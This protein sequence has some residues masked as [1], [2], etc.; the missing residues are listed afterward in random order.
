MAI[1]WVITPLRYLGTIGYY[2]CQNWL[3]LKWHQET[4][5]HSPLKSWVTLPEFFLSSFI[6]EYFV[7]YTNQ[8]VYGKIVLLQTSPIIRLLHGLCSCTC[9]FLCYAS[10]KEDLLGHVLARASRGKTPDVVVY[11]YHC[12]WF[13]S[14]RARG[15][16]SSN[17][18]PVWGP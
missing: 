16:G 1:I 9:T 17:V 3:H 10:R 11:T 2:L 18:Q 14:S 6:L 7:P 8:V 5:I 15:M 13:K 4:E 12:H